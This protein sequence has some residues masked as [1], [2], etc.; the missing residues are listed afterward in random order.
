MFD[1]MIRATKRRRIQ[2]PKPQFNL[3]SLDNTEASSLDDCLRELEGVSTTVTLTSA[4]PDTRPPTLSTSCTEELGLKELWDPDLSL[5]TRSHSVPK[6]LSE[7]I[8]NWNDSFQSWCKQGVYTHGLLP[9]FDVEL[10]RHFQV[11]ELSTFLLSKH[12]SMKMIS[13]ERWLIDSKLEEICMVRTSSLCHSNCKSK[14]KELDPVLSQKVSTGSMAS[15]RLM[16]EIMHSCV[17][18]EEEAKVTIQELCRRTIQVAIPQVQSEISRCT[19]Q[20][21][22]KKDRIEIE[23]SESSIALLYVRKRWKKPFVIK[24]NRQHY[25]KLKSMFIRVHTTG[26]MDIRWKFENG[27]YASVVHAFHLLTMVLI[28]RYSALSGGQLLNDLRGGGMQGAVHGQ[29]FSV[30]RGCFRHHRLVESFASPLNAYVSTFQSAFFDDLDWH[31]GSIGNFF[32]DELQIEGCFEANPPFSPGFMDEM[33]EHIEASLRKADKIG[34]SL[35]FVVIVP[36]VDLNQSVADM[37]PAKRFARTSFA[38][39]VSGR[40]C[41]LHF[42]LPPREHGYVEGAQHMRPTRYKASAYETSVILLQSSLAQEE[43]LDT[44][45]LESNIREAFKS[46]HADEIALRTQS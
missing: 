36:S 9:S 39:M 42:K 1:K 44:V 3:G 2:D 19:N 4:S 13:F 38:K 22:L 29:V 45:D 10:A 40:Y 12:R 11:K 24:M 32:S 8:S 43:I 33:V 20:I 5:R 30:L 46:K 41:R 6:K 26:T 34:T 14:S 17:L 23:K 15:R 25:E 31:F 28:L 16:E 21:P 7:H 35:S 37:P 27:K 18:S